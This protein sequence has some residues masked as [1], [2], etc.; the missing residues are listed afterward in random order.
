MQTEGEQQL[1]QKD[2][3]NE[4]EQQPLQN[5]TMEKVAHALIEQ[6]LAIHHRAFHYGPMPDQM[7]LARELLPFIVTICQGQPCRKAASQKLILMVKDM[8][9]DMPLSFECELKVAQI[10]RELIP[11]IF[12][13]VGLDW[14]SLRE[15]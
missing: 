4:G 1:Q 2:E 3:A 15:G 11:P 12:S 13:S 9:H 5:T 10:L 6:A 7:K 14:S 8:M